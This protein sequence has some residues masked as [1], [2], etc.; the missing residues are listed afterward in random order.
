MSNR[1]ILVA[2]VAALV[3]MLWLT[4]RWQQG[5]GGP[6]TLALARLLRRIGR[7]LWALG[8]AVEVGYFHGRRVREGI[9]LELETVSKS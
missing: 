2:T 7:W 9:R 5:E 1:G 4:H 8:E 6:I 3:M